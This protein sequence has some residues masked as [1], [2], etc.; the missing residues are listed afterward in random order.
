MELKLA[1]QVQI[2]DKAVCIHFGLMPLR[3][4]WIHLSLSLSL[5][6]AYG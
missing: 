5:N 6:P 1:T 3:K 2:Q 4:T